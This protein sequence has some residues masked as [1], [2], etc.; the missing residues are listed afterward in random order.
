[1]DDRPAPYGANDKLPE[2]VAAR[3]VRYVPHAHC[4]H[5]ISKGRCGVSLRA[6]GCLSCL[7]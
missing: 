1:M 6:F 5:W 4:L 2:W 7:L 3:G